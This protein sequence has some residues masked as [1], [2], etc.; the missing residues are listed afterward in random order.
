MN[1]ANDSVFMLPPDNLNVD[2]PRKLQKVDLR[3]HAFRQFNYAVSAAFHAGYET[4]VR[5]A[6]GGLTRNSP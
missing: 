6:R 3:L 5:T 2:L 4:I 1:S